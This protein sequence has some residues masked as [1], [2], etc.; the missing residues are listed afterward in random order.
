MRSLL[1]VFL[2]FFLTHSEMVRG[3]MLLDSAAL[4]E[5]VV[6]KSMA[7]ALQSPDSVYKLDLSRKKLKA[8]PEEIKNFRNLQILNIS[9]NDL[10]ELPAWIGDLTSL[11]SLDVSNNKLKEIPASIGRLTNLVYLGLNRNVI[12]GLPHEIGQCSNLVVLEMWDNEV[13]SLPEEIK[14]LHNLETLELR[15]ILF[16]QDEQDQI[17]QLLPDATIY[18]SPSCNC[19]K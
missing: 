17:H 2:S 12:E 6:Y 16:S 5:Q 8:L 19:G 13:D 3:Q 9:H 10:K 7:T 18:F 4:R 14:N 1:F 11:Q 15:G